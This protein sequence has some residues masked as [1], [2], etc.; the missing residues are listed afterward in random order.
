M[1][2]NNDPLANG[3]ADA[4]GAKRLLQA[5]IDQYP[6]LLVLRATCQLPD[7]TA[8]PVDLPI[9]P[10]RAELTRRVD[11]FI[12]LRQSE[13]KPA[14]PTQVRTLWGRRSGAGMSLL[15]LLNQHSV[16]SIRHDPTLQ[17]QIEALHALIAQ[18]WSSVIVQPAE[19]A[20]GGRPLS[21]T[22]WLHVARGDTE[23]YPSQYAA[24]LR[25]AMWLSP[26]R[27]GG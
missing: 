11:A 24:L 12:A 17:S 1:S 3:P 4:H 5:A 27:Q 18:A 8:N 16:Y 15:L 21:D 10:L 22:G 6:E 9:F 2:D 7:N 26:A 19:L 25:Q 13:G 23:R 14:P 20:G